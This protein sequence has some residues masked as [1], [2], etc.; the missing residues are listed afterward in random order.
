MEQCDREPSRWKHIGTMG[1]KGIGRRHGRSKDTVVGRHGDWREEAREGVKAVSRK[2]TTT[3]ATATVALLT[4]VKVAHL[5]RRYLVQRILPT[6]LWLPA[7]PTPKSQDA[8]RGFR[9]TNAAPTPVNNQRPRFRSCARRART[10]TALR[11]PRWFSI[12]TG[13]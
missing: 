9:S 5:L 10:S 3:T 1:I 2:A 7:L 11:P 8:A 12:G 13:V 6:W 4:V